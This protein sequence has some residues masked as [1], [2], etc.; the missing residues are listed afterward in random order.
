MQNKNKNNIA[1]Q[2]DLIQTHQDLPIF[3]TNPQPGWKNLTEM[4]AED[5][6]MWWSF[7]SIFTVEAEG[8]CIQEACMHV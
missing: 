1:R 8:S 6:C 4:P 7:S 3:F 2:D 5:S